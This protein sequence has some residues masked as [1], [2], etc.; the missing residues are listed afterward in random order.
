MQAQ[1]L[2]K[3]VLDVRLMAGHDMLLDAATEET[4]ALVYVARL[5][6]QAQAFAAEAESISGYQRLFGLAPTSFDDLD[7]VLLE[8]EC[9]GQLWQRRQAFRSAQAAWL[10]S[11]FF[12]VRLM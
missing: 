1:Q 9:K 11:P 5:S 6:E 3:Q 7:A 12:E 10:C 4:K 2:N 8:I